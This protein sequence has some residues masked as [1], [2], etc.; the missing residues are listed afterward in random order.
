MDRQIDIVVYREVTLPKTLQFSKICA[1]VILSFMNF[2]STN[3]YKSFFLFERLESLIS[4]P[5]I[6]QSSV[7]LPLVFI[8]KPLTKQIQLQPPGEPREHCLGEVLQV[9]SKSKFHIILSFFFKSYLVFI[10][11]CLL[12]YFRTNHLGE[13]L[14]GRSKSKSNIT[15]SYL[16]VLFF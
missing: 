10:F 15:L 5:F 2:C 9:R 11:K 16:I 13:V 12:I 3:S 7:N 6:N 8:Y 1:R 4:P 14:Q